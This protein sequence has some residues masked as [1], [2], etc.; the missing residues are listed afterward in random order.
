MLML[1]RVFI[2]RVRIKGGM[3]TC[4][5][6][7]RTNMTT[8]PNMSM[9]AVYGRYESKAAQVLGRE[10]SAA[11]FDW[12]AMLWAED[13]GMREA[14]SLYLLYWYKSTNTDAEDGGRRTPSITRSSSRSTLF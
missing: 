6:T 9:P 3:K 4:S 1:V 14:L 12:G 5:M 7:T 8:R 10:A 11:D 13:V 2:L